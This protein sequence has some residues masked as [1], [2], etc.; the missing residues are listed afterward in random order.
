LAAEVLAGRQLSLE[1]GIQLL[2]T[3]DDDL[4]E[5]VAAA[6]VIRR[7]YYGKWVKL[8]YL[9]NAKSGLCPE[10]CGYCSQAKGSTA[11]IQK[12]SLMSAEQMVQR[13]ER[14]VQ[15]GASTCCLVISG[16]GP[17][18]REVQAVA[19]ATQQIKQRWPGLKICA[20][21]GILGEGQADQLRA[22]GVDRYNH[23]L[24][25]AAEHYQEICSTHTYQQ[26]VQT[27]ESA[28]AA[29]I[30]P[31]SGLIV[32]MQESPRQ[33]V[34]TLLAL[35]DLQADSVPI[36][37]LVPIPGTPL[38]EKAQP[39]TP[40]YCLKVLCVARFL[41][42]TVEIRCSAGRE[43][44]LR[45]L[46]PLSL[47]PANSWFVSDY[48]TTPGQAEELD[49]QMIRDAGF[50]IETLDET[51]HSPSSCGGSVMASAVAFDGAMQAVARP[52]ERG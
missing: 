20:C 28:K 5:L 22:A 30:S 45:T 11:E 21:L 16:R 23:N 32:G 19:D 37:F 44:H 9:V 13:A 35:R 50:W 4:L 41:Y 6:F 2:D 31:C 34:A 3:A 15:N 43:K 29:G 38:A 33:L 51:A 18:K 46:Q 7:H 14:A 24:N 8:N 36:N 49:H 12:Y 27:V 25:T 17:S 1:E 42:P 40:H 10:D 52:D 26:R 47:Y 39:L 48:L